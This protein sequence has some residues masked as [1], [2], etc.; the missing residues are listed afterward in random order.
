M[1]GCREISERTFW[2]ESTELPPPYVFKFSVFSYVKNENDLL[3]IAE[4]AVDAISLGRQ[5]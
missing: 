2:R 1:K 3:A 4:T 5:N